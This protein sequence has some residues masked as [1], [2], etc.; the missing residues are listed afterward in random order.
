MRWWQDRPDQLTAKADGYNRSIIIADNPMRGVLSLRVDSIREEYPLQLFRW[1]RSDGKSDLRYSTPGDVSSTWDK[2]KLQ[3][4]LPLLDVQLQEH[5]FWH[6]S[7]GQNGIWAAVVL[8]PFGDGPEVFSVLV[9]GI[10]RHNKESTVVGLGYDEH[11]GELFVCG[12]VTGV[13]ELVCLERVD[14]WPR[15][16]VVLPG[17]TEIAKRESAD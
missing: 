15:D 6:E 17:L 8:G 1:R 12:R 14:R 11:P 10:Q 7:K 4:H 13:R 16:H 5:P 9:L 3:V 2:W